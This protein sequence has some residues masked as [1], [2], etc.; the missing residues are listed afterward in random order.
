MSART[1]PQALR[2]IIRFRE[3][4]VFRCHYFCPSCDSEWCDEALVV[5]AAYSPCCDEKAEPYDTEEFL[6]ER[7]EFDID[8]MVT[9]D[10]LADMDEECER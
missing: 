5:S 3:Q 10:M 6:V 9:D 8:E 4:R 2:G 1:V 7:P